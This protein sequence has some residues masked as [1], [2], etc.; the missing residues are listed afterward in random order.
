MKMKKMSRVMKMKK[1]SRVMKVWKRMM[2]L[3]RQQM[4]MMGIRHHRMFHQT[5]IIQIKMSKTMD[6][7]SLLRK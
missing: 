2:R 6:F 4:K 7:I 1:M 3:R 5:I